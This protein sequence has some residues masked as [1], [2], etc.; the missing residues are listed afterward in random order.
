MPLI[1]SIVFKRCTCT[2]ILILLLN[3][4]MPTC[5]YYTEKGLIYIVIMTPF[6]Y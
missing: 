1:R 3:E 5:S 2:L 6:S 4:I